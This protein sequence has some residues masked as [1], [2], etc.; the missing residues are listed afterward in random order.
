M[1]GFVECIAVRGYG[2]CV[3][4]A[5]QSPD[6]RFVE[7]GLGTWDDDEEADRANHA[8]WADFRAWMAG[9]G[10]PSIA[11]SFSEHN[12]NDEGVLTFSVSRNHRSSDVW[13]MLSWIAANGPGSCGLFYVH[14]DEDVVR[15][16][17]GGRAVGD[18]SNRFRV[19]RMLHGV[20]SE[21]ADPFFG[22]ISPR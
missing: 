4:R 10:D 19:H 17:R 6:Q 7:P 22:D 5:R 13:E 16:A 14:D 18:H 3:L 20:V 15:E 9:I 8:F 2:W 21:L 12:N 1:S 11:W